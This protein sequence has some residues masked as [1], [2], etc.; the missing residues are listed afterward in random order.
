MTKQEFLNK[1]REKHGYKYEYPNLNDK[2]LSNDDIDIVY[3]GQYYKQKISKHI[4]LG[5]CPEKNTPRKTTEEFIMEARKI[6]GNKYDYSLVDYKNALEKVK[7]IYDGIIFEQVATSHLKY[8]PELLMNREYFIKKAIDKWGNKYDYSLVEYVHC[9]KHVKILY[10]NQLFNQTPYQHLKCAPENIHLSIRKTTEK[11]I[12]EA[13]Q[14]HDNKYSYDKTNYIKNQ[15]KVIIT[16]PLHGDFEQTPLSHIGGCG[17][18]HCHE[19]KGEKAINKF[20]S[21]N[22]I[23]YKRQH[24]FSDCKNIFQLPFDF[25]IPNI[26]TVIEF[27]GKQHFE[28]LEYF[29]GLKT[30]ERLKHND[31]IKNSYCED[32]FINIIR[33]RYDQINNI[34][35][36]LFENLKYRVDGL[37][38]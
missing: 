18:S 30:Y 3:N 8:A 16:C 26:R 11:F 27:D 38:T 35:H 2:I 4:S 23:S 9:K 28:P 13:N 10:N 17:C 22:N 34:D 19:S 24:K 20:L 32:S 29:G 33:I 1:A 31:N 5:R 14:I 7:I 36:I 12:E 21:K 25:Y 37:N 15:I 6:W